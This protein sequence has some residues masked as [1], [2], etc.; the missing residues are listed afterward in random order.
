MYKMLRKPKN[1]TN[2]IPINLLIYTDHQKNTNENGAV[3]TYHPSREF[4]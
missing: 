1:I 3:K 4:T 2:L